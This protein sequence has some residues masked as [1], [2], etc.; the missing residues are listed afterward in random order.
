MKSQEIVREENKRID[1]IVCHL[2]RDLGQD[3]TNINILTTARTCAI[4]CLSAGQSGFFHG[5]SLDELTKR[6]AHALCNHLV[7]RTAEDPETRALTT[8]PLDEKVLVD[9]LADGLPLQDDSY[10]KIFEDCLKESNTASLVTEAEAWGRAHDCL[11]AELHALTN[12][13]NDHGNN[14]QTINDRVVS[15]L[16]RIDETSKLLGPKELKESD[17]L[18]KALSIAHAFRNAYA[19]GYHDSQGA[20]A[21]KQ[22]AH[23]N[24][25]RIPQPYQLFRRDLLDEV[26]RALIAKL[27]ERYDDLTGG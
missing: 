23:T 12:L 3:S 10:W 14:V 21:K 18:G 7:A 22:Y 2:V 20:W 9:K 19:H 15:C 6:F 16:L 26:L 13:A 17:P 5:N 8:N 25:T 4:G 27:G 24:L 1:A 11:V